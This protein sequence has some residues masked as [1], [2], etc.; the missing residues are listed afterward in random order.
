MNLF[1]ESMA[2][3]V[4]IANSQSQETSQMKMN[5]DDKQKRMELLTYIKAHFDLISVTLLI[6]YLGYSIYILNKQQK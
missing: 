1:N 6:G 3:A 2:Q 4:N 5:N